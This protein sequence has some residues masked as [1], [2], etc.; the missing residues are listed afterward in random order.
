[1]KTNYLEFNNQHNKTISCPC[2]TKEIWNMHPRIF[3]DL[4]NKKITICPYCGAKYQ[5]NKQESK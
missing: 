4:T 2:Y 1:M 5:I 3:L